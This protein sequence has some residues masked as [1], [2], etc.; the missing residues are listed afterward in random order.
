MGGLGLLGLFACIGEHRPTRLST[1]RP[2]TSLRKYDRLGI[3]PRLATWTP[4]LGRI[5]APSVLH[6]AF[7]NRDMKLKLPQG[8]ILLA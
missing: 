5:P 6:L 7:T 2:L 3:Q 4:P 8:N 1:L